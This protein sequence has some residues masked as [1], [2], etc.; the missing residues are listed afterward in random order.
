MQLPNNCVNSERRWKGQQFVHSKAEN[1]TWKQEQTDHTTR[2]GWAVRDTGISTS[3]QQ[4]AGVRLLRPT[5]SIIESSAGTCGIPSNYFVHN[6][7]LHFTFVVAGSMSLSA[8]MSEKSTSE[9][10]ELTPGDKRSKDFTENIYSLQTGDAFATP[11]GMVCMYHCSRVSLFFIYNVKDLLLSLVQ[12]Q[13][14]VQNTGLAVLRLVFTWHINCS[15]ATKY[16]NV[17][18][19]LLLLEVCLILFRLNVKI[20]LD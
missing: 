3:T 15:Q 11:P 5:Q 17:S 8:Q 19:D 20:V 14:A 13:C 6:A 1:A 10:V 12:C 9:L 2:Q 4:L 7:E 18:E 16:S